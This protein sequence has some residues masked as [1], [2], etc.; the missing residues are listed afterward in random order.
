[1][2]VVAS[3]GI[4]CTGTLSSCNI[5]GHVDTWKED[6]CFTTNLQLLGKQ[7]GNGSKSRSSDH[8]RVA[9]MERNNPL[10]MVLDNVDV[11]LIDFE[12]L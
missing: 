4:Q 9:E 7:D 2:N 6:R 10:P 5:R 1:M 3:V 12:Y 11:Y 8:V